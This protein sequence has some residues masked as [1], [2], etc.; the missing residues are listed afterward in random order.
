MN[1]QMDGRDPD[2]DGLDQTAAGRARVRA[3]AQQVAN[4][5]DD[6]ADVRA[7]QQAMESLRPIWPE[8]RTEPEG[9]MMSDDEARAHLLAGGSLTDPGVIGDRKIVRGFAPPTRP[10]PKPEDMPM[11][12]DSVR[13]PLGMVTAMEDVGHPGGL[14]AVIREA[15]AEWLAKHQ[16]L[17]A[18]IRDARQALDVLSGIVA[19]IEAE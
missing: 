10:L 3:E 19:R 14:S 17:D 15:V 7:T 5:P 2:G 11:R 13:L 8:E 18:E 4:D 16:G 1:P 9:R 6:L 12:L